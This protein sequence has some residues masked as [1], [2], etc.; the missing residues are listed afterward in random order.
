MFINVY[1]TLLPYCHNIMYTK[2]L[3]IV[4]LTGTMRQGKQD[5]FTER[6]N[7]I[8]SYIS[9]LTEGFLEFLLQLSG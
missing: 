5:M 2:K 1:V 8:F 4:I 3:I 9:W 6:E 7:A